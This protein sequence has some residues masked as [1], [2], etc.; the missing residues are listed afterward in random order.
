M[1][2]LLV[3]TLIALAGCA[4]LPTPESPS[5]PAAAPTESAQNTAPSSAD[6]DD[7]CGG[8]EALELGQP[9]M[10]LNG[11]LKLRVPAGAEE[12]ARTPDIMSAPNAASTETRLVIDIG[13]ARLVVMTHAF[14]ATETEKL[15][16]SKLRRDASLVEYGA[17]ES[18]PGFEQL[19]GTYRKLAPKGDT[20]FVATA[21]TKLADN[22]LQE[23]LFAV[24]DVAFKAGVGG[25]KAM[26]K[27]VLASLELGPNQLDLS[28]RDVEIEGGEYSLHVPA[29]YVYYPQP[30]P[31]FAVYRLQELSAIGT[32]AAVAGVYFGH[33]ASFHPEPTA[34]K[35]P[36]KVLGQAVTWFETKDG[37]GIGRETLVKQGEEQIHLFLGAQDAAHA[38]ALTKALSSLKHRPSKP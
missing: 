10:L 38:E 27:R 16:A 26:A 6:T 31:D 36:G 1:R 21:L 3:L 24:N 37:D 22:T 32:N 28:E 9:V 14:L 20:V 12:S 5:A 29:G 7:K 34:K 33:F 2:R 11:A 25:C 19:T 8:F 15:E 23:T 35:L 4:S 18:K 17:V 30:G 13:D